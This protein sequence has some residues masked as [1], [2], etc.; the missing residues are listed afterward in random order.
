MEPPRWNLLK[1]VLVV[2]Q[3]QDLVLQCQSVQLT[4]KS[5]HTTATQIRIGYWLDDFIRQLLLHET[6]HTKHY[7]DLVPLR[8]RVAQLLFYLT[9][10]IKKHEKKSINSHHS[11]AM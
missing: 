8:V 2:P 10:T 11:T 9:S 1:E 5:S 7:S 4:Y 3:K 6:Y